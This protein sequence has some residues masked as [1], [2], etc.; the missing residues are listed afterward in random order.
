VHTVT[1]VIFSVWI[2]NNFRSVGKTLS[3]WLLTFYTPWTRYL[4]WNPR[5]L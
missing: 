5:D 2:S 4:I 1:T 3:Y